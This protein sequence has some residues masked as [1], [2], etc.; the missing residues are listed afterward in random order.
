MNWLIAF[1]RSNNHKMGSDYTMRSNKKSFSGWRKEAQNMQRVQPSI[2]KVFI[3]SDG[4]YSQEVC[5]MNLH[6][7]TK[8]VQEVGARVL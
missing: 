6:D 3:I 2:H 4:Q 8:Y 5:E 1:D 7:F